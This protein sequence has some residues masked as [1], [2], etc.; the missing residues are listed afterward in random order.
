MTVICGRI[1]NILY[2]YNDFCIVEFWEQKISK[3][4]RKLG[5]NQLSIV[6]DDACRWPNFCILNQYT[7]EVEEQQQENQKKKYKLL[8]IVSC[9]TPIDNNLEKSRIIFELVNNYNFNRKFLQN[10]LKE[11]PDTIENAIDE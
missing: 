9:Q 3:G 4:K 8:K 7:I 10:T 6:V 1:Y 11:L 2:N 5:P